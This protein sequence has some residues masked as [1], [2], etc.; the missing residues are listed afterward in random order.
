MTNFINWDETVLA[1]KNRGIKIKLG[2]G[3]HLFNQK[4]CLNLNDYLKNKKELLKLCKS[5][6]FFKKANEL[7]ITSDTKFLTD[8]F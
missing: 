6:N 3:A 2:P 8:L 5:K 7:A 1:D 4:I